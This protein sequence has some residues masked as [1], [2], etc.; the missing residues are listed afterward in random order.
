VNWQ[1]TC[2]VGVAG[3]AYMARMPMLL[4]VVLGI[5]A[6]ALVRAWA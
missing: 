4:A 1:E 2:G 6:T 3:L 5:V